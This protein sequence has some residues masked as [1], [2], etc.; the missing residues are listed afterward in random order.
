[1]E[2]W[3]T[4]YTLRSCLRQANLHDGLHGRTSKELCALKLVE[5]VCVMMTGSSSKTDI[6]SDITDRLITMAQIGAIKVKQQRW[7]QLHKY[8]ILV[9]M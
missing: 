5:S 8:P 4:T 2:V 6:T 7:Y 3:F 9:T 1:M